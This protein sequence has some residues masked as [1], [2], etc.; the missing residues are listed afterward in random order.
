MVSADPPPVVEP[1]VAFSP[2]LAVGA[3]PQIDVYTSPGLIYALYSEPMHRK[4]LTNNQPM[5]CSKNLDMQ[6]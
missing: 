1:P 5:H 4:R 6:W 3:S 2:P